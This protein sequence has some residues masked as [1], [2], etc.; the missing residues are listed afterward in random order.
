MHKMKLVSAMIV[1]ALVST[2]VLAA[3]K[4][5]QPAAPIDNIQTV[6]KTTVKDTTG[7]VIG[8]R[9][10]TDQVSGVVVGD[11]EVAHATLDIT[12]C[13]ANGWCARIP[14]PKITGV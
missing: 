6:C 1:T 4:R 10:V 14:A 9:T 8:Q 3:P 2:T 12:V 7:N 5:P 11:G 13:G